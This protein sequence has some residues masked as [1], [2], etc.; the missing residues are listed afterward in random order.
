MAGE[1]V[2]GT[3]MGLFNC[4][5]C[6]D[7]SYDGGGRDTPAPG[8]GGVAHSGTCCIL[9]KG[10]AMLGITTFATSEVTAVAVCRT[11]FW[12][13]LD[14]TVFMIT[15]D[16]VLICLEVKACWTDEEALEDPDNKELVLGEGD[17]G[18]GEGPCI[19]W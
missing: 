8:S 18:I 12:T 7:I 6:I 19:C 17:A 5:C 15:G 13:C 3:V 11:G 4:F 16:W 2:L 10:L 1:I 9:V 14:L